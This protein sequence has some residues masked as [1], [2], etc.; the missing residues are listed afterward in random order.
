MDINAT[1]RFAQNQMNRF[2]RNTAFNSLSGIG[3]ALAN[4]ISSILIARMT[5]VEG[6][7]LVT[8]GLWVF[9]VAVA[10]C[11]LG[12]TASLTRFLPEHVA[13]ERSAVA[14][15]LIAFLVRPYLINATLAAA[16]FASLGLFGLKFPWLSFELA[17]PEWLAIAGLVVV[18]TL[19][20]FQMAVLRGLQ[21]FDKIAQITLASIVLQVTCILTGG[22]FLGVYGALFGYAGGSII[23][24]MLVMNRW[25]WGPPLKDMELKRRVWR[26]AL[27]TW[28]S[29]VTS[30][31]VWSRVE[32]AF[33][34]H[35]WGTDSVGLFSAGLTMSTVAT[36]L[37]MLL[38]GSVMPWFSEKVGLSNSDAIEEMLSVG[39]RLIS[40]IVLPM[41]FGLAGILPQLL[42]LLYGRAFEAASGSATVLVASA[43]MG[44]I[45]AVPTTLLYAKE[46]GDFIFYCGI[47]GAM[48]SLICGFTLVPRYGLMGAAAGRAIVQS[49]MVCLGF[50]FLVRRLKHHLPLGSLFRVAAAALLCA[51]EARLIVTMVPGALGV[52]LAILSGIVVYVAAARF[53]GA[54]HTTDAEML[55]RLLLNAPVSV[56]KQSDLMLRVLAPGMSLGKDSELKM[57]RL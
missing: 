32:V 44:A 7:G 25:H 11:D 49:V 31:L 29:T 13:G 45:S 30:I 16:S 48:L 23:P 21:Q 41:C 47:F 14:R 4:F 22:S 54:L 53:L 38:T 18:G 46:R 8:F 36:Q 33:L 34:R 42:P 12:I 3:V 56:R 19:G 35:Y 15:P 37:P 1:P 40:F 52:S 51:I 2:V 9:T 20:A 43:A 27:Y 5:G 55:Q 10:I 26:F 24:A 17:G 57:E 6:A 39:T 50:W 28:A